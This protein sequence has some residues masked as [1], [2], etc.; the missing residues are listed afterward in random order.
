LADIPESDNLMWFHA[1]LDTP[2]KEGDPSVTTAT[3]PVPYEGDQPLVLDPGAQETTIE[4]EL[5]TLN[6][7][8]DDSRDY[9]GE[10]ERILRATVILFNAKAGSIAECL[11]TAIIWERG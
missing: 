11:G 6:R 5:E 4:W 3:I 8:R 1:N 7:L 9:D 2:Y 10:V